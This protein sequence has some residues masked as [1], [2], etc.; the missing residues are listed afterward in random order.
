MQA[1]DRWLDRHFQVSRRGSSLPTELLAGLSTFL[2][3][4][5]I[6][7]ANP[8][9]LAGAGMDPR[10][11]FVATCL[12]SALATLL[13]GCLANMP[14]ALAPGMGINA[15]FAF[16]LADEHGWEVALGIV[17]LSGLLFLV[18]SVLPVRE[19][20]IDGI[21]M[22]LKRGIAAGI[23]FFIILL[24]LE[25]AKIVAAH[26]KTIVTFGDLSAPEPMLALV[27]FC[28]IVV[29]TARKVMGA[30]ILGIACVT[31]LGLILGISE[32]KGWAAPPTMPD[33]LFALDITG[34]LHLALIPA[35]LTLLVIDLFD[36]SGTLIGVSHQAGLLDPKGRLPRIRSAFV[37]DATGTV[38]GSL[39]GTSTVTSYIESAAGTSAGGRTGLVSLVVAAL[40]LACLFLG[41]VAASV[42]GFAVAPALLHVGCLMARSLSDLDWDDIAEYAPVVL[43]LLAIPLSHSIS[44]GIGTGFLCWVA[45]RI[46]CG[47]RRECP[48]AT[49]A[50]ALVFLV[51]FV[52]LTR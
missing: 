50:I 24:G 28:L 14:V 39:L 23:G 40:F 4:A 11:V 1:T 21:P 31:L 10:S 15:W 43:M 38:A 29:L 19:W 8:E 33:T 2:A 30:V 7:V 32:W 20:I 13:M 22:G 9:I 12:A 18:L 36:S 46:L 51:K 17:F 47:R 27:G 49:L 45:I 37:A 35:I 26:E 34:A 44:D 48:P 41:P 16:T 5:Y 6:T 25:S 3:M 42:P 52:W